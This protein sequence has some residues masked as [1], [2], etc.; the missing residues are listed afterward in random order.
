VDLAERDWAERLDCEDIFRLPAEDLLRETPPLF[1]DLDLVLRRAEAR[2][3][4]P[5]CAGLE[6]ARLELLLVDALFF[7]T[8]FS[9]VAKLSPSC[10]RVS[11]YF[12]CLT[13]QSFPS[14]L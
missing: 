4:R 14:P 3:V 12:S 5:R 8:V 10:N 13:S 1:E 2:N 9:R 7:I 6:L 11:A